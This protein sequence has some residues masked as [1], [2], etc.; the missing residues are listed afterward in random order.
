MKELEKEMSGKVVFR[1]V[2]AA[3]DFATFKDYGVQATPVIIILDSSGK[4]VFMVSGV[5]DKEKL[6][7]ELEK[8]L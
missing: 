3:T 2:D 8:L 4:D 1:E 5:P 7:S 6:K